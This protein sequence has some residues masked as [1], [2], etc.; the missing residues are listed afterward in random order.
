MGR[1]CQGYFLHIHSLILPHSLL[2][3][4]LYCPELLCGQ[5]GLGVAQ[6]NKE[7]EEWPEV[8][9]RVLR[10]GDWLR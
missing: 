6:G 2:H 10:R 7:G 3:V 8:M 1:V 9:G 5:W 4:A